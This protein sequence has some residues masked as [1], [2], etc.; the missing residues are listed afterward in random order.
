[1]TGTGIRFGSPLS[2]PQAIVTATETEL[3]GIVLQVHSRVELRHLA[4]IDTNLRAASQPPG[5]AADL[6]RPRTP[7]A[8]ADEQGDHLGPFAGSA[9]DHQVVDVAA[10]TAILVEQLVVEHV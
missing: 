9:F 7:V 10:P 6:A 4:P 3:G 5:K 2:G 8:R 1:M